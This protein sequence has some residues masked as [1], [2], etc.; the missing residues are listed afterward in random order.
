MEA[1]FRVIHPLAELAQLRSDIDRWFLIVV[2]FTA[3]LAVFLISWLS[4]RIS[5]PLT[6]LAE[7]TS[8]IDLDRLNV[9]FKTNRKDEIGSLSRLLGAMTDR[10]R[11]SAVRIKV[12]EREA[13][14]GELARQ[15]NHDIKNGLT[16]IRNV[17][18]HLT[19]I[20]SEDPTRLPEVLSERKATLEA[21]ITYLETLASN[22][23][24]LTPRSE[25]VSCDVNAI[26]TRVVHDLRGAGRGR[27]KLN[28][29][30]GAFV[31]G[32][33]TSIRRIMENLV[34]N[35]LDS[36][37]SCKG[38]VVVSTDTI[39]TDTAELIVRI[40]VADTGQGMTD[41]QKAKAFNDFYTTKEEG[42]GLGLSIVRRLVMDMDGSIRVESEVGVG[43]RFF[44]DLPAIDKA[45]RSADH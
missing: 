13:T 29:R 37:E 22:Y 5:K 17:V 2:A 44:L 33:P 34:A 38:E 28:T 43:S 31:T 25:R 45:G 14:R 15:V 27:I 32:D 30:P 4:A 20:L 12:A 24:R 26:V 6:E 11:A 10:L 23:A 21:S 35:A 36:L 1:S 3:I 9:N 18:T 40:T 7:K 8:R 42:T 41:E 16:P 19:E 39:R